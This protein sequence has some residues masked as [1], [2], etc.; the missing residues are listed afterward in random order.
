M[1]REKEF[2]QEKYGKDYLTHEDILRLY[3]DEIH[4]IKKNYAEQWQGEELS[5]ESAADRMLDNINQEFAEWLKEKY[6]NE[7]SDYFG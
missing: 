6:P 3:P 4:Q 7:Y 5:D 2:M 1:N